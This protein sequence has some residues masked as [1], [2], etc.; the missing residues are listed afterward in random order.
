MPVKLLY[1]ISVKGKK[2]YSLPPLD[3]PSIPISQLLPDELQR[4]KIGLPQVSE[5]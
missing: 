5:P 3:V 1:E 4:K 2:A